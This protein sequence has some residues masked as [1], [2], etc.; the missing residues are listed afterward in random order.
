[1]IDGQTEAKSD[2]RLTLIK[3]MHLNSIMK[4]QLT[5][6]RIK[7]K[8]RLFKSQLKKLKEF[9]TSSSNKNKLKKFIQDKQL[10]GVSNTS[11][12]PYLSATIRLLETVNK[13]FK[14][15]TV[16]DLK[17]YFTKMQNQK[18]SRGT[19]YSEVTLNHHK[20][21]I[22]FFYK[23]LNGGETFPDCVKWIKDGGSKKTKL[24]S[25][26]MLSTK[27]IELL[28][29]NTINTRDQAIISTLYDSAA[30]AWEFC[31]VQ[32]KDV[33]FDKLGALMRVSGKTGVRN[34]R[35]MNSVPY[36]QAWL[37]VHPTRDNE[38][39][40]LWYN[41]KG[42]KW[43]QINRQ[44]LSRIVNRASIRTGKKKKIN[45]HLFRHSR[46]TELAP[47][48]PEQALKAFAG[49]GPDS[50]MAAIYIHMSGKNVD[51]ALAKAYG[52]IT[53]EESQENE[54]TPKKCPR[55][56]TINT[57]TA[58]YCL[59]CSLVL[60]QKEA[61]RIGSEQKDIDTA[62]AQALTDPNKLFKRMNELENKIKILSKKN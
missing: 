40:F 14:K 37:E 2:D 58:K 57:P 17:K 35:L 20:K 33:K 1:M 12:T 34:I 24:V 11:I 25:E 53:D 36:L 27:E 18:S 43:A 8:E 19:P 31:S 5:D 9:K 47:K 3:D 44:T 32:I 6:G 26:D 42:H 16:N 49:W 22:K 23:W 38:E 13:D 46:L 30:R 15:I 39:S 10:I 62:I 56:K 52:L 28:I 59:Q 61:I 29:R 48:I 21:H 55:C 4:A 51:D 41:I 60:D 7:E 54:L 50:R 45:P